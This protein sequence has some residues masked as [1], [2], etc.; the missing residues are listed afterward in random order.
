[1]WLLARTIGREI[2]IMLTVKYVRN[3]FFGNCRYT[4]D[5]KDRYSREDVKKAFQHLS[6]D[7]FSAVQ[8]EDTVFFLASSINLCRVTVHSQ[9]QLV[10]HFEKQINGLNMGIKS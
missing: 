9:C 1:M 3:D 7:R 4:E 2:D 10:K 6:N 5:S 8:K